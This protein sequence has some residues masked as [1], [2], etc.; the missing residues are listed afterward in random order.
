MCVCV[1]VC[2]PSQLTE[3][4]KQLSPHSLSPLPPP[5]FKEAEVKGH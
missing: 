5:P 3:A 2:G 1:C 4:E